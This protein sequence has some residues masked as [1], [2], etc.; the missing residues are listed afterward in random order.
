VRFKARARVVLLVLSVAALGVLAGSAQAVAPKTLY[1]KRGKV[2]LLPTQGARVAASQPPTI[3]VQGHKIGRSPLRPRD[4]Q[5]I[6]T[7][8]KISTPATPPATGWV[9]S[10]SSPTYCSGWLKPAW[11]MGIGNWNWQGAYAQQYHLQYTVTWAT[12]KKKKLAAATYDFNAMTDYKCT[13]LYCLVDE[14]TNKVPFLT[15]FS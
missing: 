11:T 4:L 1:G 13:T 6:C 12:K 7:T 8:Y 9:V 2:E 5:K 14:D 3:T 15:F 10:A